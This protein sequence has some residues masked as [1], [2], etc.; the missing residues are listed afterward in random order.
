MRAIMPMAD[1]PPAVRATIEQQ[2]RLSTPPPRWLDIVGGQ[3]HSRAWYEWHWWRGR[4]PLSERPK[5]PRWMR[6]A[7]MLRDGLLCQI[8]LLPVDA[9]DVHLDHLIPFSLGGPTTVPN[10]RVT[11][12]SCNVHRGNRA[13]AI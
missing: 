8:C 13:E 5:I 3:I 12:S 7:V 1:F 10:L 6:R 11:H 2:V 4:D 9:S